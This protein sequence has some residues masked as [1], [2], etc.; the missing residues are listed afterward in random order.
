M[1]QNS[2]LDFEPLMGFMTIEHWITL[3]PRYT[4]HRL[5]L[6]YRS[7]GTLS[8]QDTSTAQAQSAVLGCQYGY[9]LKLIV[10]LRF[11]FFTAITSVCRL[12]VALNNWGNTY[13][14]QCD[15]S[16]RYLAVTVHK[17]VLCHKTQRGQQP[18]P[19][20]KK[21]LHIS[22]VSQNLSSVTVVGTI[23]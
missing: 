23:L 8:T 22:E 1:C 2:L 21:F 12:G 3:P 18:P 20:P 13:N 7:A 19:P 6:R 10:I 14:S 4:S 5:S 16:Q 17:T 15:I 9:S 11:V